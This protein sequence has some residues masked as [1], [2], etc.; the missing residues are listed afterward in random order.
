MEHPRLPLP[1]EATIDVNPT[2]N[3]ANDQLRHVEQ[4][5]NRQVRTVINDV[6]VA[7][8]M[9]YVHRDQTAID[10][11]NEYHNDWNDINL[12]E[13]IA[14]AYVRDRGIDI[15]PKVL[16]RNHGQWKFDGDLI[17]RCGGRGVRVRNWRVWGFI[18]RTYTKS[19]DAYHD[20]YDIT[21][22]VQGYISTSD[23]IDT[24]VRL[25]QLIRNGGKVAG[26]DR[27]YKRNHAIIDIND[28][29]L[30]INND[31]KRNGLVPHGDIFDLMYFDHNGQA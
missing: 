9:L 13:S 20:G 3:A 1:T 25:R 22:S 8:F 4:Y 2:E 27:N 31:R 24:L 19:N 28:T 23:N 10:I 18:S 5:V 30:H 17:M 16:Q 7:H 11:A 15:D 21:Q 14:Q 12:R 26:I 29:I 6:D